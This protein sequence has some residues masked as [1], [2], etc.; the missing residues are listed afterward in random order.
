MIIISSLSSLLFV[1]HNKQQDIKKKSVHFTKLS[2]VQAPKINTP[3][4]TCSAPI[5]PAQPACSGNHNS[6]TKIVFIFLLIK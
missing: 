5:C 3:A 2:H 6:K 1:R 4:E